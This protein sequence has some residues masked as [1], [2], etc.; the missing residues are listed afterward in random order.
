MQP[1]LNFIHFVFLKRK[2]ILCLLMFGTVIVNQYLLH[3]YS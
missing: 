3:S 2:K 1:V